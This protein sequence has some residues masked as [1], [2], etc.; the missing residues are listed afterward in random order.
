MKHLLQYTHSS[1]H[2]LLEKALAEMDA[3]YQAE[4]LQDSNR[5]PADAQL[6]AAFSRPLDA[7]RYLLLGESPYPRVDSA[8]GHAFWDASV[9]TLWS[10]TGFS[11]QVN[12]ATSLRNF[13]KMLLYARKDLRG[14]FS[15]G[16]I[17]KLEK[18]QYKQ[19]GTE[20]F[21]GMVNKGFVLLNASLVYRSGLV[22][23]D[24]R[25]WRP[26]MRHLLRE[27][28]AQQPDIYMILLGKIAGEYQDMVELPSLVAE[29]PFNISFIQ[30]ANVVKFFKPLDLLCADETNIYC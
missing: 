22:K 8:N 30:N 6:F 12:R 11:K 24:S 1:W 29:H 21:Q 18:K 4:V 17:A 16:S 20:L 15:Q 14:D 23:K 2:P 13:L 26:F 19:T 3:T 9:G 10:D 25:A 27:I 5:L 28:A 7:T